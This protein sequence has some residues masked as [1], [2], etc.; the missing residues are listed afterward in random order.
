MSTG[1]PAPAGRSLVWKRPGP[2]GQFEILRGLG[3]IVAPVLAGFGLSATVAL[4]TTDLH[5]PLAEPAIATFCWSIVCLLLSMQFGFLALR[6][7]PVPTDRLAWHP[8]ARVDV[9]AGERE[10]VA[11]ARDH[12]LALH[13]ERITRRLYNV[14]LLLF[15][16]SIGLL[17]VPPEFSAWRVLA[18]AGLAL[19]V[20]V[21]V[22]WVAA[23]GPVYRRM[24]RE[25]VPHHPPSVLDDVSRDALR[26]S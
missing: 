26:E 12:A 11:Q 10:R 23:R 24:V 8:E 3:G 18:L 15:L 2:V 19:G 5:L 14:G 20:V 7:A 25:E 16:V 22:N 17:V 6:H 9:W 1:S 4:V 21:E 13:Y